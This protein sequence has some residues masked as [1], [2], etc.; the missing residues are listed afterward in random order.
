MNIPASQSEDNGIASLTDQDREIYSVGIS[1]GGVAEIRMAEAN[2]D[3]HIVA[4]TIDE[5]GAAFAQKHIQEKRLKGQIEVKIEDVSK[6]LAYSDNRFDY[7]YARLVLHYLSRDKLDKAVAEL[8][9]VLK[10]SGKLFVVVR[11]V[12]C[13]DAKNPRA[14][15]DPKSGLTT[16]VHVDGQTGKVHASVRYFHS[17]DSIRDHVAKAGFTVEY[18]K[19]Y[20]ER[21][22]T[23]FMR[24]KL[25]P[26]DDNVVELAAIK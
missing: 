18:T 16:C 6:P 23:D 13:P 22:F 3:R 4:T 7:I 12:N 1:T 19:S 21:L 5:E 26:H 20:D 14:T 2:P 25:A 17:E 8:Y 11:S 15:Y 9:R 10:P 24:T